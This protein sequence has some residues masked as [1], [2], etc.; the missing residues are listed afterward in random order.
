MKIGLTYILMLK[1][2]PKTRTPR[3]LGGL[4]VAQKYKVH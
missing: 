4:A 1:L 3:R 2:G